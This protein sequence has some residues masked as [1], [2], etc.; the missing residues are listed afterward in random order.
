MSAFSV[1][2]FARIPVPKTSFRTF[3]KVHYIS[4]PLSIITL[5]CRDHSKFHCNSCRDISVCDEAA[6]AIG[7]PNAYWVGGSLP[8]PEHALVREARRRIRV[9]KNAGIDEHSD[10]LRVKLTWFVLHVPELSDRA[11]AIYDPSKDRD[12]PAAVLSDMGVMALS[13]SDF[14]NAIE[15][16]EKRSSKTKTTR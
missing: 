16:F 14:S 2:G 6:R 3:G 9:E 5:S 13:N 4:I 7:N 12:P 1:V 11:R 10:Q 15:Y 8:L